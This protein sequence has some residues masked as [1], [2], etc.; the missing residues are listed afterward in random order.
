MRGLFLVSVLVVGTALGFDS[1]AWFVRR[2]ELS[3]E[4]ERLQAA[5]S[6]LLARVTAPSEDVVLPLEMLPSGA[7]ALSIAAKRA[8]IFL[9]E[10]LVW[11]EGVVIRKMDETGA[12]VSRIEAA[13]CLFDRKTKSGWAEGPAKI[14]HGASAFDG[15]DV[16]FSA[17]KEYV[18]SLKGARIESKDLK[19]GGTL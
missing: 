8:Q 19:F 15:A 18:M 6:N 17:E 12:E 1:E 2:A 10:H 7:I 16:Y 5:Y 13:T 3:H 4:A 14:V 9:D 11:A